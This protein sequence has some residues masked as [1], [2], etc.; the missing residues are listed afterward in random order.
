MLI[1]GRRLHAHHQ[2]QAR[3]HIGVVHMGRTPRLF[4]IVA[5]NSAFLMPIKNFDRGIDI[6]DVA[7]A[8]QRQD[9]SVKVPLQPGQ[10]LLDRDCRQAPAQRILADDPAHAHEFRQDA[11]RA[12]R[13]DMRIAPVPGQHGKY[14]GAVYV[15]DF[16]RIGA[17]IFERAIRVQS[18]EN[19]R[20]LQELDE[21]HRWSERRQRARTV[22]LYLH[23]SAECIERFPVL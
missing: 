4:G 18:I 8:K 15:P 23:R 21:I 2:A 1:A 17:R 22:P 16:W 6:D 7:L 5:D 12:Q 9:A 13:G 14:P 10:P 3:Q 20:D 11:V 19:T